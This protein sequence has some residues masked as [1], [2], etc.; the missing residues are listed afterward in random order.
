MAEDKRAVVVT[1]DESKCRFSMYDPL[2]CKKCL[3]VCNQ[4][5]Y[6]AR[7][8]QKRDFSVPMEQ[9]ID[10]TVWKLVIP[11]EDYCTGCGSCIKGCPYG[12][13]T[14]TIAG[15]QIQPKRVS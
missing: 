1:I 4:A 13:I 6:A 11:W 9:R 5:V 2:G 3:Q 10:P 12:A 15:V 14:V 8:V 7:P